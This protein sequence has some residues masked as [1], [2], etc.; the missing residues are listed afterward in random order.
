MVGY[1]LL[2]NCDNSLLLRIGKGTPA[3]EESSEGVG[4]LECPRV[5]DEAVARSDSKPKADQQAEK[6][7]SSGSYNLPGGAPSL[8]L[9]VP[10][11]LLPKSR[12]QGGKT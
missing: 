10:P 7:G 5:E 2:L 6:C 1:G 9:L 3:Q 8:A 11:S 12:P 4:Y